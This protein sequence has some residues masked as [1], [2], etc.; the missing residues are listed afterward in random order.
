MVGIAIVLTLFMRL[1][2]KPII[3]Q[4]F[5]ASGGRNLELTTSQAVCVAVFVVAISIYII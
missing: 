3:R 4:H 2:G 5:G 1:Y